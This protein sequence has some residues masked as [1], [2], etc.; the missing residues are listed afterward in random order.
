MVVTSLLFAAHLLLA[1][2][3]SAARAIDRAQDDG[4]L[5][6]I[7]AMVARPAAMC[8]AF[9]QRKTLVGLQ[10]P[11]RSSGRFCVA[12]DRG[13]LWS[14]QLPFA[15]TLTLTREAIVESQGDHVTS[16]LSAKDEPTV[17][18]ISGLLFAVLAGDFKRLKGDFT[19]DAAMEGQTWRA[20]LVPKDAGM[21]RVIGSIELVGADYVRQITIG[22]SSG[23]RTVIA[24]SAIAT[25]ASALQ[26]DDLRAFGP[27]P[28]RRPPSY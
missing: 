3:P 9:E 2:A 7:L 19:I 18:V 21:R 14:T 6:A 27:P 13:V 17:G 8:G 16:R 4:A 15:S 24:F 20:R 1:P 11:V 10:R 5:T 22:E 25:G 26:P 12:A 28:A 23:D